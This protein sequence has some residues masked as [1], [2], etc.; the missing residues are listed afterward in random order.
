MTG[1]LI[2]L[3]YPHLEFTGSHFFLRL[4]VF[5]VIIFLASIRNRNHLYKTRQFVRIFFPLIL[6]AYL[7]KETDY[8][9]NL[10][11]PENLDIFF[12]R[13]EE[14]LF[15]TQPSY[16]FAQICNS[17]IFA[18]LMYFGYFSYYLLL[19]GI[20]LYFYFKR[21]TKTAEQLVFML[22]N[23]FLIY[24]ILFIILPVAGPQF[25]FTDWVIIPG[26]YLF[27]P[28]MKTIQANGEAP[29]AAFPSSHVSICLMVLMF[30]YKYSRKL[31]MVIIPIA[32]L[33]ILS[34]V[35]IR[36]HYV[37][38]VIA[39]IALTPLIYYISLTFYS[40]LNQFINRQQ[41]E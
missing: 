32:T 13:I 2:L 23:S 34:T 39:A 7:Y 21:E 12:S 19:A 1:L 16:W 30:C 9:N 31:L 25:Y 20:P 37:I 41:T 29:T 17:N 35:Y 8:L 27:G 22:S 5:I 18:E 38:D 28:I 14:G 24:Y 36:A 10:I 11:F 4:I 26:G 3:K 6:L 15:A 33:L 40:I